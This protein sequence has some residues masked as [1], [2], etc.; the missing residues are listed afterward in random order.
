MNIAVCSRGWQHLGPDPASCHLCQARTCV[1]FLSR[2]RLQRAE[3]VR[4]Q[5]PRAGFPAV[6]LAALLDL[7]NLSGPHFPFLGSQRTTSDFSLG[8]SVAYKLLILCAT[9]LFMIVAMEFIEDKIV[10]LS[11]LAYFMIVHSMRLSIIFSA[12]LNSAKKRNSP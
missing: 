4:A 12:F 1:A 7:F 3:R 11:Q 5:A 9:G 10:A 6:W 2:A 8:E